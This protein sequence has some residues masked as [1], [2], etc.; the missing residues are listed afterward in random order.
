MQPAKAHA[1]PKL[2]IYK[3]LPVYA[4][5]RPS[6]KLQFFAAIRSFLRTAARLESSVRFF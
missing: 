3:E 5:F 4:F 1:I 2:H 6:E